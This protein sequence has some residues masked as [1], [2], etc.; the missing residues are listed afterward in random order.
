[1]TKALPPKFPYVHGV[2]DVEKPAN[3]KV[4]LRGS[5]YRLGELAH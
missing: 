1:M 3:L 2:K 5:A 4:S